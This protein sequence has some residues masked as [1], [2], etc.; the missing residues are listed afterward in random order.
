MPSDFMT[1]YNYTLSLVD[2]DIVSVT[3]SCNE[4]GD[5]T[6]TMTIGEEITTSDTT[7]TDNTSDTEDEATIRIQHGCSSTFPYELGILIQHNSRLRQR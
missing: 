3:T 5:L 6:G 2:G 4:D 1:I 7:S